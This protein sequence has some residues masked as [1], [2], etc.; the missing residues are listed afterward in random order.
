MFL[1][2]KASESVWGGGRG[3]CSKCRFPGPSPEPTE[4]E[5]LELGPVIHFE[6]SPGDSDANGYTLVVASGLRP[7]FLNIGYQP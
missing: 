2:S 5:S 6:H 3:A 1:Y 7:K 4:S